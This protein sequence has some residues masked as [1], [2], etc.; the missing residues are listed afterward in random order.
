MAA[1][2]PRVLVVDDEDNM[3][4]LL[5][6]VLR[7][8]R[9]DTAVANDGDQALQLLAEQDFDFVLC[10]VRMPRM[11]GMEF[12]RELGERRHSVTVILMSAFGTV[13]LAIEAMKA[14][15]YDYISKPF[16]S[17]EVVLT[18]RK[19]VERER[20]K[21]DNARLEAEVER[22]RGLDNLIGASAA[23]QSVHAM[24][25]KVAPHKATVLIT[26][27]SGTGKELVARA[28]HQLSDRRRGPFVALNCGAIPETLLESELFGH[29]K[30]AFTDAYKTKIGRFEEAHGGTLFLDEVG[31]LPL[32][33]QSKLLRV[34]QEEEIRRV[35]DSRSLMV[36]TRV[37]AATHRN[38]EAEVAA[39]RF[40]E[41]LFYRLNVVPILIP[42]LR[43]RRDDIPVLVHHF[44]VRANQRLGRAVRGLTPEGLQRLIAHDWRGNVRELENAIE[45]ALVMRDAEWLGA[46]DFPELAS[47][48]APGDGA[49]SD[50][51]D[52]SIKRLG[53]RLEERLIRSAL[54]RTGGNRSRAA[55][56]LEISHRAL[57]LKIKEYGI[58]G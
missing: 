38:L 7:K 12:L 49:G 40:R 19:A 37:V 28:I 35:G 30:G 57:L 46:E 1:G 51:E 15:A 13:D 21:R 34:L 45:R 36:D 25:R 5:T 39:M 27:E 3:R 14:G 50:P 16:K 29:A 26:G 33:L 55:R 8:E 6:L 47:G 4:H 56:L 31:E 18:L 44:L 42:P 11:D 58:A 53:R 17:D 20:L 24:I 2:T 32:A 43:E 23:M 10:D 48:D 52:L 22:S 54:E 9:Y 41:D